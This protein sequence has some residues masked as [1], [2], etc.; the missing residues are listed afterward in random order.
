MLA[1]A[2]F[3]LLSCN[4]QSNQQ[5]KK[6]SDF[7]VKPQERTT[8][9]RTYAIKGEDTLD[10]DFYQPALTTD[11]KMPPLVV[12]VHGGGFYS[13]VR[14]DKSIVDFCEHLANDGIAAAAVSYRLYLKGQSFDCEQPN[15]EKIK[16]IETAGIDAIEA[17]NFI[18]DSKE[19]QFD[20]S[21]VA[22][23]GSSAGAEAILHASYIP[24]EGLDKAKLRHKGIISLA[25][26]ITNIQ[27]INSS[28]AKPMLLFHGTCDPL[29]PYEYGNHHYCPDGSPG[30]LPLFGSFS[31]GS[32][33]HSNALAYQLITECGAKHGM[34]VRPLSQYYNDIVSFIISAIDQNDRL[35]DHL[36]IKGHEDCGY[37]E[38]LFC[39]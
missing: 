31:I 15:A 23:A 38:N 32:Y 19:F 30:A 29:V 12:F 13:G 36:V 10:F 27:A 8:H 22:L 14:T 16:A 25:G 37:R 7:S 21:K 24:I 1:V 33:C 18:M 26:A 11:S 34:A 5:G 20:R 35:H 17:M 9:T 39:K 6:S 28:N 4:A 3:F 2:A